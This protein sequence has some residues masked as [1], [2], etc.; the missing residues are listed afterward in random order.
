MKREAGQRPGFSVLVGT[1]G[2][3]PQAEWS[4]VQ[5][6]GIITALFFPHF[7]DLYNNPVHAVMQATLGQLVGG[8]WESIWVWALSAL[9]MRLSLLQWVMVK[10][11]ITLASLPW[12]LKAKIRGLRTAQLAIGTWA[13]DKWVCILVMAMTSNDRV[14]CGGGSRYPI[15][16]TASGI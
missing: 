2:L 4:V 7:M 14:W 8:I 9:Y 10:T 6:E 13:S 15:R 3:Q 12:T 11:C 1:H 16:R 5:A